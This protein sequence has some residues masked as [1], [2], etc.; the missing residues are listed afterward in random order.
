MGVVTI[1]LPNGLHRKV[2]A[3]AALEGKLMKDLIVEVLQNYVEE[4]NGGKKHG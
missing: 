2:K 3:R 1:R 4:I